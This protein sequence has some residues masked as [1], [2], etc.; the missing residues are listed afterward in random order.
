MC[1]REE[2]TGETQSH[3][4]CYKISGSHY[5]VVNKPDVYCTLNS[6]SGSLVEI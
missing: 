4:L 5:L 3:V 2:A 6:R 1:H